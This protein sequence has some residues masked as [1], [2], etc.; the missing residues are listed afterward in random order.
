MKAILKFFNLLGVLLLI[1]VTV[2]Q[3]HWPNQA[4]HVVDQIHH[5]NLDLCKQQANGAHNMPAHL[6]LRAK[7]VLDPYTN[8][9]FRF[10][11]RLLLF[12][13]RMLA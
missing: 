7:D 8:F 3:A 10:V 11:R 2:A 9:G 1:H 13:Q 5:A 12:G 4:Q 6:R